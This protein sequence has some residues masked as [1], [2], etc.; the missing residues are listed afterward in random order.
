MTHDNIA[1]KGPLASGV[2]LL[3]AGAMRATLGSRAKLGDPEI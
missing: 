2:W 3:K 1:V